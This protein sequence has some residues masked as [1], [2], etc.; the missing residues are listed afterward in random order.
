M[1][2][3]D[4]PRCAVSQANWRFT[5][6]QGTKMLLPASLHIQMDTHGLRLAPEMLNSLAP[7]HKSERPLYSAKAPGWHC[8]NSHPISKWGTA[9]QH[10][11]LAQVKRRPQGV[12]SPGLSSKK[13]MWGE[14]ERGR[15]GE[16]ERET[17][18]VCMYVRR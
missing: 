18:T 12:S 7:H 10:A 3:D 6:W 4:A 9:V 16:R 2:P 14:G 1:N 15:E 8:S 17:C 11:V 13:N 5:C